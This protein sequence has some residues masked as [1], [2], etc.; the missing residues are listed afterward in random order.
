MSHSFGWIQ[1]PG[2]IDKLFKCVEIF[3]NRTATYS[4]L[5]SNLIPKKV[6]L[7]DGRDKLLKELNSKIIN[8]QPSLSYRGLI[9]TSFT[10]RKSARCNG[11]IQ[12]LIPGQTR[13]FISDWPANNFLRWAHA[14]GFIN[15]NYSNDTF[16]ISKK[17]LRVTK[18]ESKRHEQI[19]VFKESL[20]EYP[21]AIRIL[22]LLYEQMRDKPKQPNLTKFELGAELGFRGED[23]FTTYPQQIVVHAISTKQFPKNKILSNWEGSSD[24]YARMICSWLCDKDI[25]WIVRNPK[26]VKVNIGGQFFSAKITQSYQMHPK[27]IATFRKARSRS[28]NK[29]TVKRLFYEMLATKGS[30]R[31]YLRARRA[32]IINLL[33]KGKN[34]LQQ[35]IEFLISNGIDANNLPTSLIEDD[36]KNFSR[37]G[38][39]VKKNQQEM[40]YIRDKIIP[41]KIPISKISMLTPSIVVQK[42]AK[43]S[44]IITEIP[45][46]FL[47][48]IDLSY[49]PKQ[50]RLFEMRVIDLL[51]LLKNITAIHLGGS[52]RPDGVAYYPKTNPKRGLI[53][54]TK[55]YSEGFNIPISE[56]DKMKRYIDEYNLKDSVLNSSK[57]WIYFKKPIYPQSPIIFNFISSEFYGNYVSQIQYIKNITKNDG[58][59]ITSEKLIEKVNSVLDQNNIYN[60][61]DFFNDLARNNEVV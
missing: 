15:Y 7:I 37:I 33:K 52:N 3:D 40:F 49:D 39:E 35:I 25:E 2:S 46:T 47:D 60:I 17:G 29:G 56:R 6:L 54:D 36:I 55:A 13:N 27:G 10:P 1:D 23:G 41:L 34:D 19:E 5:V 32:L 11:I 21:P 14:M 8:G 30:D 38:L 24:K 26:E 43:L 61:N 18:Y 53:I 50:N 58:S 22:E 42:K 16:C 45:H 28:R 51:N 12:A 44:N 59:A 31:E 57:W 20:L 9:G 4:N 48:L